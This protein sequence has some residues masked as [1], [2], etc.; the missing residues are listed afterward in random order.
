MGRLRQ[1]HQPDWPAAAGLRRRRSGVL[2]GQRLQRRLACCVTASVC[3]RQVALRCAWA[4]WKPA[5]SRRARARNSRSFRQNAA[6]HSRSRWPRTAQ[7]LPPRNGRRDIVHR[8]GRGV[9]RGD[10]Q[11]VRCQRA[12]VLRRQRRQ[13]LQH[14][15]LL[16]GR[17]WR[18]RG[19]G[20]DLPGLRRARRSV[21]RAQC[22]QWGARLREPAR[23]RRADLPELWRRRRHL[24]RG[25]GLPAR[26]HLHGRDERRRGHLPGVRRRRAD[27]LRRRQWNL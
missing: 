18:R 21:L 2:R 10:L 17:R 16:P 13:Q 6:G 15:L 27:V 23:Q 3:Q 8:F 22:L 20:A 24:L 14:R 25:R 19:R 7:L 9:R 11:R 1:Q 12:R 26:R 4:A 5:K